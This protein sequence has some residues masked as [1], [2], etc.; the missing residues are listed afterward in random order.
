ML[1]T[2]DSTPV[3]AGAAG[4][5]HLRAGTIEIV[6]T[7]TNYQ[8][9]A[10]SS[11]GWS[12]P[13][14]AA[15]FGQPSERLIYSGI[16]VTEVTEGQEVGRGQ[17]IGHIRRVDK[18]PAVALKLTMT[19]RIDGTM[20]PP[21]VGLREFR[22]GL[23]LFEQNC[24]VCHSE[25]PG[26]GPSLS[27]LRARKLSREQAWSGIHRGG[28]DLPDF[29]KILSAVEQLALV[30]LLTAKPQPPSAAGARLAARR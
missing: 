28:V 20:I 12:I 30:D 9:R 5:A 10:G 11:G 15:A 23:E 18:S 24:A 19:Y 17:T 25:R 3:A 8:T 27:G 1:A 16:S 4:V 22:L 29:T 2:G 13:V 6:L 21:P 7:P 14:N 26:I